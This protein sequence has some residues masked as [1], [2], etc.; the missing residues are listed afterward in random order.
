MASLVE[1]PLG[2]IK[3]SVCSLSLSI[4]VTSAVLALSDS[5]GDVLVLVS[6]KGISTTR[7]PL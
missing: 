7:L 6:V 5:S 3:G 4:S 2:L 1:A